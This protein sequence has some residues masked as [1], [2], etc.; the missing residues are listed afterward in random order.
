MNQAVANAI[1][2]AHVHHLMPMRLVGGEDATPVGGGE[3]LGNGVRRSQM[4]RFVR[5]GFGSPAIGT[6]RR[7]AGDDKNAQRDRRERKF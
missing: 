5:L 7:G 6:G 4:L 1:T 2:V 3:P